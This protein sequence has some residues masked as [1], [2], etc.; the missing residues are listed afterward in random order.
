MKGLAA[1]LVGLCV[2]GAGVGAQAPR[3]L[4]LSADANLASVLALRANARAD[5]PDEGLRRTVDGL[6]TSAPPAVLGQLPYSTPEQFESAETRLSAL[7]GWP[8]QGATAARALEALA[9]RH[10]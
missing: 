6:V 4:P 1:A 7:L 3:D 9:R 2:V 8:R 10:R 5:Q